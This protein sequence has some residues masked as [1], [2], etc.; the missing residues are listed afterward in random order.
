MI[1]DITEEPG[2]WE[3]LMASEVGGRDPHWRRDLAIVAACAVL[4]AALM[5]WAVAR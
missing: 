2:F 5:I 3:S 1:Y 4:V